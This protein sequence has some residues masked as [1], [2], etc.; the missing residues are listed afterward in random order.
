MVVRPHIIEME[1]KIN[2]FEYIIKMIQNT[3]FFQ[4]FIYLKG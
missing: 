3:G 1:K 4:I 2:L